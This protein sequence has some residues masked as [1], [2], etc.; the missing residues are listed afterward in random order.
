MPK[1]KSAIE[2]A[3]KALARARLLRDRALKSIYE[4]HIVAK[5]SLTEPSLKNI[6]EVRVRQLVNFEKQFRTQ[7]DTIAHALVELDRVVI[8]LYEC[9]GIGF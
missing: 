6:L 7:Q 3:K 5:N 2:D 9:K 8:V 1:I 4:I